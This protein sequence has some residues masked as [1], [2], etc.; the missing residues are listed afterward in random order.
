VLGSGVGSEFDTG[1][2][3]KLPVQRGGSWKRPI[4]RGGF[5]I[6]RRRFE[7]PSNH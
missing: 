5:E 3:G 4:I 7:A 1:I 6:P 2:G